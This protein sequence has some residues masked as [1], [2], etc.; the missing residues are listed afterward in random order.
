[1]RHVLLRICQFF[2]LIVGLLL[3]VCEAVGFFAPASAFGV[4]AKHLGNLCPAALSGAAVIELLIE[5]K[6]LRG[7]ARL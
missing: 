4:I 1:M 5:N 3:L 6:R 2:L 7:A